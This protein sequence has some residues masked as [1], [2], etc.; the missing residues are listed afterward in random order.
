MN[1]AI[2]EFINTMYATPFHVGIS[3]VIFG[4]LTLHP[5]NNIL[6]YPCDP[7]YYIPALLIIMQFLFE[8]SSFVGHLSGIISGCLYI[9][10]RDM[11]IIPS[12]GK[13]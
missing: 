4:I 1:S 12:S 11:K 3:G 5:A 9:G 7:K 8:N 10:V 2:I 13:H 6:G